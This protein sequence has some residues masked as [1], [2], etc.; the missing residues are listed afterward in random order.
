MSDVDPGIVLDGRYRLGACVGVGR[1]GLVHRAVHLET[2][3]VVAIKRLRAGSQASPEDRRRLEREA[4]ILAAIDHPHIVE[5]IDAGG[6]E[7]SVYFVMPLLIG[8]NLEARLQNCGRLAWP[9]ARR[10]LLELCA[11]LEHLHRL[12]LTHLDVKPGNCFLHRPYDSSGLL[13]P[14]ERLLLIDL[15]GAVKTGSQPTADEATGTPAYAAPEQFGGAS[16]D[17]RADVH[18]MGVLTFRVLTGMLPRRGAQTL[19]TAAP[20]L[21]FSSGL[22]ALVARARAWCPE[23]R[24]PGVDD[25][26][27]ELRVCGECEEAPVT[28]RPRVTGLF[29]ALAAIAV[30]GFWI[31]VLGHGL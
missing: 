20:E 21:Q 9:Q 26:A 31:W 2:G 27:A 15:F 1:T 6:C 14:D 12:G 10:L 17:A 23:D 7:E 19:A 5:V 29:V 30:L 13:I 8:E 16:V 22:E 25:F 18:A 28:P 24:H 4:A 11:A 3:R